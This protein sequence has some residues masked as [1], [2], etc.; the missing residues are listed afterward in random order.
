MM[1]KENVPAQAPIRTDEQILPHS[2]WLQIGKTFTTSSSVPA[3]YIQQFWN[4]M[5]YDAKT[6]VYT[7][8]LDEQWFTLGDDLLR[9]ALDITPIDPSHPFESPPAGDAVMDFVN[10]LGHHEPIQFATKMLMNNL[11]QPWRAI[12]SLINQCLTGKTFGSDK[13]RHPVLQMLWGIVTRTNVDHAKLLWEEFVQGDDFLL[14]NLKFVPKETVSEDVRSKKPAPVK[15]TKPALAKQPQ[16]PK[17][18]PSKLTPSRKVRKRKPSLKLVDEEEEVQHEPEPQDEKTDADL[19]HALKMSLDLSQPQGQVED[20]AADL[21][22]A[23]KMIRKGK[24]IVTEEQAAH[25]LLDLHKSKKKSTTE[26]FILQ[27]HDDTTTGPSSQPQD[28][29]SEKVVQE[30][31][32]PSD[33]TSVAEKK[34]NSERTKSGTEV[35]VQKV[36]KEQDEEASTTATSRDKNAKSTEDQAR[37]DPGIDHATLTGSDHE[38]MQMTEG[39]EDQARSDPV[40][41]ENVILEEPTSPS[42][43]L[44]SMKNLDDT[45]NFGDDFLNDVPTEDEHANTSAPQLSTTTTLALPPHPPTQSPTDQELVARVVILERRNAELEHAF[46]VHEGEACPTDSGFKA[47]QDRV[48]IAKSSTLPHDSAPRIT[49]P[50]ADEGSMQLK[51]YELM[52]LCTSMQR[53]HSKMVAKFEAHE[54]EINKLKARVELLEDKEGVAAERSGNDAPIKGRNLDEGEAAAERMNIQMA[55]QLEEE[56][57]RD[58]QRMNEQIARDT[59]IARIYAKKEL[60]IMIDRLDSSN[61]TVAKYQD[62]YAKVYKFQTQQRKPWSKKQKRNYYMAVIKNNLCWKVKEFRG[63]TFEEIEAKFTTVWKQLKYCIPIGSK[64]EAER[65]KRKGI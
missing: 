58:A 12:L 27:R 52:G 44:S 63:M 60:Q 54:L 35:E 43:I 62:N 42:G 32:S 16:S 17:K 13:P 50:A 51:L 28:E 53:Q 37:S 1:A 48:N 47:E 18:K 59:E 24:A 26:H 25:S 19:E 22:C 7:V 38:P 56:M 23:L 14:G 41:D 21:E 29:T 6:G 11:R 65:F 20:E 39:A 4:T 15:Q 57:E 10:Q 46:M 30:T 33:S 45:D 9:K 36:D 61:E 5:T 40:K 2:A 64:E 31:S 8:Q 34:S 49:S 3:I 55:R